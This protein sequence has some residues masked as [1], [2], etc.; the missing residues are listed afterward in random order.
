MERART[1]AVVVVFLAVARASAGT[2]GAGEPLHSPAASS[3][4]RDTA[5]EEDSS[6]QPP[7]SGT[8]QVNVIVPHASEPPVASNAAPIGIVEHDSDDAIEL[9]DVGEV[10]AVPKSARGMI[11]A[12]R[13]WDDKVVEGVTPD[14]WLEKRKVGV[15]AAVF[16]SKNRKLVCE[17]VDESV[18]IEGKATT[19]PILIVTRLVQ[20]DLSQERYPLAFKTVKTGQRGIEA[21]MKVRGGVK[22]VTDGVKPGTYDVYLEIALPGEEGKTVLVCGTFDEGAIPG[23]KGDAERKEVT[24]IPAEHP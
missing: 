8:E 13:R 17:G 1:A 24:R 12:D 21:G 18:E 11:P 6:G 15:A 19:R 16:V 14:G 9:T 5:G 3:E 22:A 4:H 10:V 7:V 2:E 23:P 20:K